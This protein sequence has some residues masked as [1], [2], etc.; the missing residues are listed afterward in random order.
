VGAAVRVTVAV[1][2]TVAVLAAASRE[3]LRASSQGLGFCRQ[4]AALA[5]LTAMD[6][7]EAAA[8]AGVGLW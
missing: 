1:W 8:V 2:V 6:L 3:Y 7:G 5:F 4:K